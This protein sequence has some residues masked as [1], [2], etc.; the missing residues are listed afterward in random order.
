MIKTKAGN[1]I[2]KQ[3]SNPYSTS[4]IGYDFEHAV[5]ASFVVLML[6][7]G[8]IPSISSKNI[9]KIELQNRIRGIYTDD[10]TVYCGDAD[11]TV[12]NKMFIQIKRSVQIRQTN[13]NFRETIETTWLDFKNN[14]F[15]ESADKLA[16]ITSP[17]SNIDNTCIKELLNFA[18]GATDENNFLLMLKTKGHCNRKTSEKLN[19]IKNIIK[20]VNNDKAVSDNELWRFLKVF[21]VFI[22][23]LD[24]KGLSLALLY[25][26]IEQYECANSSMVWSTIK[27]FI[28]EMNVQEGTITLNN[29]PE[30]IK[31]LFIKRKE[32]IIPQDLLSKAQTNN[33]IYSN[34]T[35]KKALA[36]ACLIGSWS[37]TN[38]NDIDIITSIINQDYASWIK[39][40]QEIEQIEGSPVCYKKSVWTIKNR[41]IVLKNTQSSIYD[42]DIEKLQNAVINVLTEIDPKFDLEKDQR[43]FAHI[44]RKN[45]KYSYNLQES[46]SETVA[47][48]GCC[49]YKF[50]HAENKI[51]C[52]SYN[53]LNGIFEKANWQLFATINDCIPV[54]AESEPP[55]F[56]RIINNICNTD[57]I[58]NLIEQEGDGF[59]GGC[60]ISGILRALER[61]AWNPLY[62]TDTVL[63]LGKMAEITPKSRW[64][65]RPENSITE[66]FMPWNY[67]TLASIEMQKTTIT[68]LIKEHSNIAIQVLLKLLPFENQVAYN[69]D[70]PKYMNL[71][72]DNW[73]YSVKIADRNVL[74]SYYITLLIEQTKGNINNIIKIINHLKLLSDNDF[75]KVVNIMSSKNIINKPET[76][77]VKLWE[78]L[79]KEVRTHKRFKNAAWVMSENRIKKLEKVLDLIKPKSKINQIAPLYD[80][81]ND[82]ALYDKSED[83]QKIQEY[84]D[85]KRKTEL[86]NL[87]KQQPYKKTIID[88]IL[89]VENPY[90]VANALVNIDIFNFDK[91]FFP[92]LIKTKDIK[93]KEFI[94]NYI[95]N[96]YRKLGCKWLEQIKYNEWRDKEKSEFLKQLPCVSDVW[97]LIDSLSQNIKNIYWKTIDINPYQSDSDLELINYLLKY[98][99][100]IAAIKCINKMFHCKQNIDSSKIIDVLGRISGT[101]ENI[102][103]L[104]YYSVATMI[105]FLQDDK[106]VDFE[107]LALIE[108]NFY[109]ALNQGTYP[110]TLKKKLKQQPE[111]F[112]ELINILYKPLD[113]KIAKTEPQLSHNVIQ[114]AWTVLNEIKPLA[115][116][117][118]DT[119]LFNSKI[120]LKWFKKVMKIAKDKTREDVTLNEIGQILFYTPQ[121]KDGFWINKDI[122]EILN[123]EEYEH[124]RQGYHS[125]IINSRG[126]HIVD[127]TA[128]P[129]LDLANKYHKQANDCRNAGYSRL[130]A[131][132][133]DA[134]LFYKQEAARILDKPKNDDKN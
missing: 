15:D 103:D 127:K 72:P 41:D 130:A 18:H 55:E 49:N 16:L 109:P 113:E 124:M 120:F 10:L 85:K 134:E 82:Y 4:G 75:E 2:P 129:E 131:I 33:D 29:I 105:K 21:N 11:L 99:R 96:K 73:K 101:E 111:F 78:A 133:D 79:L 12:Y 93:I 67:Q 31:Q 53:V 20:H 50:I 24:I 42:Q 89:K 47:L 51:S 83:Y 9:I 108:W 128:K 22:Y 132:L 38:K 66:I 26:I 88:L 117:D 17:M 8:I 114:R 69:T 40:L 5:Q 23:D 80:I 52:F 112:C 86:L 54:L 71:F 34:P 84:F 62:Y 110:I 30:N 25:T 118:D 106:T 61:L 39:I 36:Y 123:T 43:L 19:V 92:T 87:L 56:I 45:Y 65:N 7:H 46:L 77:R 13:K 3:M 81:H 126:C 122:A 48:L 35:Y 37:E 91:D 107:K 59:T 102:R 116:Y 95:A 125:E 14:S 1:F 32:N 27:D 64:S 94:H 76:P 60:Y 98:N 44:Y 104:D 57:I 74:M 28:A 97:H 58:N 119:G 121:D 6:S 90:L 68:R 100:P 70:K 63:L 115:G